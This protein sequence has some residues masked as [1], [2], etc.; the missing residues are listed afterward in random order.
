MLWAKI[1]TSYRIC[2]SEMTIFIYMFR[3]WTNVMSLCAFAFLHR[4]WD[5]GGRVERYPDCH[6]TLHHPLQENAQIFQTGNDLRRCGKALTHFY[7]YIKWQWRSISLWCNMN[8]LY[9][10][11]QAVIHTFHI[12][13]L[14][15]CWRQCWLSHRQNILKRFAVQANFICCFVPVWDRQPEIQ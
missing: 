11:G 1:S 14:F 15:I 6:I 7:N 2:A 9:P 13:C 3:M 5:G 12:I 4:W 8:K 10:R